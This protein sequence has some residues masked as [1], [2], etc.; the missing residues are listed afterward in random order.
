MTQNLNQKASACGAVTLEDDG[1]EEE[2]T[3]QPTM[4][5]TARP[6]PRPPYL[7]KQAHLGRQSGEKYKNKSDAGA[8]TAK[9]EK[10]SLTRDGY[11]GKCIHFF[12]LIKQHADHEEGLLQQDKCEKVGN[13][14]TEDRRLLLLHIMPAD[15]LSCWPASEEEGAFVGHGINRLGNTASRFRDFAFGGELTSYHHLNQLADGWKGN[16]VDITFFLRFHATLHKVGW[17]WA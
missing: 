10:P 4:Y 15:R 12:E 7:A 9:C 8:G 14:R 17:A 2:R 6:R 1:R 5:P 13:G 11:Y 3:S 16:S